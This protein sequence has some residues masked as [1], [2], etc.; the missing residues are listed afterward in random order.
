METAFRPRPIDIDKA[1]PIYVN[2]E[3]E[4]EFGSMRSVPMAST[5][6]DEEEEKEKHLQKV[7]TGAEKDIPTPRVINVDNYEKDYV[8]PL[9]DGRK[10]QFICFDDIS[11]N[12]PSY[13][14]A[15]SALYLSILLWL[16]LRDDMLILNGVGCS[17]LFE[18][19]GAF[20]FLG[21]HLWGQ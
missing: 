12:D 16:T 4:A 11:Y 8:G 6:M 13:S 9:F 17:T 14:L 18:I 2:V 1:I 21:P 20:F 5:G 7:I 3:H 19:R 10:G 15:L